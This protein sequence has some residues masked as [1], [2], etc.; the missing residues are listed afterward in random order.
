[1]RDLAAGHAFRF[2]QR[3]VVDRA[4]GL[5]GVK[6]LA[7]HRRIE[8]GDRTGAVNQS[9]AALDDDVGIAAHHE[10]CA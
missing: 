10:A 4:V 7:A 9:R 1:M 6:H 3:H 2:R 5:A 8:I